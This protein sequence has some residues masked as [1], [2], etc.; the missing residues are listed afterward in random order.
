[1]LAAVLFLHI[2]VQ[3]VSAEKAIVLDAVTGRVI[4]ERNA[5]QRSLIASTAAS[6]PELSIRP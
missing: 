2:P 6:L 1:M 4:Y 3:A 5:D